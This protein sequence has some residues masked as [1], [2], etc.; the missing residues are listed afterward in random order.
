MAEAPYKRSNAERWC[1]FRAADEIPELTVRFAELPAE[2]GG[3][4][5]AKRGDR[6]WIIIDPRLSRA[7][8]R[9]RLA[10]EL[11]HLELGS[12]WRCTYMPRSWDD[13][14]VRH[15]LLV[16]R[17]VARRLVPVGD[18]QRLIADVHEVEP[19]TAPLV[20]TAFGVPGDIAQ[21]ALN[22]VAS[23]N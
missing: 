2:T 6:L 16:D 18:L 11:V 21:L 4:C 5:L 9:Y 14:V 15:E 17:E 10:H 22:L 20:A 13:L 23:E 8:R 12:S 1:P 3:A 19:V 7:D